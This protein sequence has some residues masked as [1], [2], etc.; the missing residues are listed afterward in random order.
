MTETIL[1]EL[2][3]RLKEKSIDYGDVFRELGLAGQYSDMHRKMRK[4]KKAMWDDQPLAG[5]QPEEILSDLFG[6]IL[7]ALYLYD[8][9][10]KSQRSAGA[11]PSSGQDT[12]SQRARSTEEASRARQQVRD[13]VRKSS[14]P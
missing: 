7:I 6:N 14:S 3:K 4:L 8:Y 12:G 1:P 13:A 10:Q 5:E 9:H 2:V 11:E